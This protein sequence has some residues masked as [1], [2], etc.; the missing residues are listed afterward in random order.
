METNMKGRTKMATNSQERQQIFRLAYNY[1]MKAAKIGRESG[2][3]VSFRTVR[4]LF[5]SRR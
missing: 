1:S 3:H 4:R 5:I 2:V